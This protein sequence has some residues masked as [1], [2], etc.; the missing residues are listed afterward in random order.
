MRTL[1]PAF[2]VL[3]A[4]CSPEA[5][6]SE[7]PAQSSR[8]SAQALPA[9]APTVEDLMTDTIAPGAESLWRAVSYVASEDGVTETSPQSD[10]DWNRLRDSANA[11]IAAGDELLVTER[12][13]LTNAF[14]P[15]TVTFQYSPDE[16]RQMLA[17]DPEPWRNYAR[18]LQETTRM[19]LQAIEFRDVMGLV[20]F[21][22][23]IN[24]ACEGCHA[25]YWYRAPG[26]MVPQ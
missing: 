21:G 18:Q 20:E 25:A 14:D 3:L 4:A 23:Q 5:P 19:T 24:E 1:I 8:P 6:V 22:A 12:G 17:E 13:I 7:A 10:D 15:A 16:I 26:V 9:D 2:V 11:L